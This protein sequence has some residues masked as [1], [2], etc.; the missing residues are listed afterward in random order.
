MRQRVFAIMLVLSCSSPLSV[1]AQAICD[2]F[3]GG[4]HAETAYSPPYVRN[5]SPL[6]LQDVASPNMN[7]GAPQQA[8][9]VV[10][11]AI[12]PGTVVAQTGTVSSSGI[13]ATGLAQGPVGFPGQP[14]TNSVTAAFSQ[15]IHAQ[16]VLALPNMTL[17]TEI[18]YVLPNPPIRTASF[19]TTDGLP[20]SGKQRVLSQSAEIVPPNT[21]GAI[22]VALKTVSALR[23]KI[24]SHWKYTP[25]TNTVE[26]T[27]Q[28]VDRAGRIVK[29]FKKES[30]ER[31]L[32]PWPHRQETVSYERVTVK[33]A[34]PLPSP[35][36]TSNHTQTVIDP[37]PQSFTASYPSWPEDLL[38]G[39]AVPTTQSSILE[40]TLPIYFV[41]ERPA[42]TS[43]PAFQRTRILP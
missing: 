25:L 15:D 37:S 33:V 17:N 13:A 43:E 10:P 34:V 30:E 39:D 27:V 7:L 42:E 2:I 6:A 26:T 41:D 8:I 32:L 3:W 16:N 21:P 19:P 28:V 29:T 20:P 31:T 22:P 35:H 14:A 40:E 36:T 9:P 12:A 23:P 18:V 4:S 11:S 24:E 1:R 38:M 5:V